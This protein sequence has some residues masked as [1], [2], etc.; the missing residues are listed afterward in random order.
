MI[1]SRPTHRSGAAEESRGRGLASQRRITSPIS[2]GPSW[3]R[4]IRPAGRHEALGRFD[5]CLLA[6]MVG[7]TPDA[8]RIFPN[9]GLSGSSVRLLVKEPHVGIVTEAAVASLPCDFGEYFEVNEA[10][11][12]LI[13]TRECGSEQFANVADADDG[14]LV[15]PFKDPMSIAGRPA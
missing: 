9:I 12:Y 5:R 4:K 3:F 13:G 6:W 15:K 11:H 7:R 1:M 14:P 10:L 8:Y 2:L